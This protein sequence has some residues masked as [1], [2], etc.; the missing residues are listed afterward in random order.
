MDPFVPDFLTRLDWS[1][2]KNLYNAFE[3]VWWCVVAGLLLARRTPPRSR[4][5]RNATAAI[6]FVFGLSDVVELWSGAW[7]TPWWLCVLKFAC[8]GGGS[9]CAVMWWRSERAGV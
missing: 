4:G 3:A 9:F 6:L 7:W 8:G 5:W 2:P 1:D